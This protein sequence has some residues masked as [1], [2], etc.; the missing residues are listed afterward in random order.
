[1]RIYRYP[2]NSQAIMQVQ[3]IHQPANGPK[4]EL[5]VHELSHMPPVG[6]PF[7]LDQE[8]C[9]TSKA[10]FGPDENGRYLLV[11][12]GEPQPLRGGH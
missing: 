7:T 1:M 5:G 9:Y 12:D 10:Y 11:L 4:T 3:I 8:V 2:S 6:E